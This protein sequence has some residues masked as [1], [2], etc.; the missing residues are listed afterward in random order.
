MLYVCLVLFGGKEMGAVNRS[1]T[2]LDFYNLISRYWQCL[3]YFTRH[4]PV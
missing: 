2:V 4:H 1:F 3:Q